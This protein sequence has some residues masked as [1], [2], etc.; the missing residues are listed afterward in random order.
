ML[1]VGICNQCQ[2]QFANF[3]NTNSNDTL[4]PYNQLPPIIE[5]LKKLSE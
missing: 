3:L 1:Q 4:S 2:F 5:L